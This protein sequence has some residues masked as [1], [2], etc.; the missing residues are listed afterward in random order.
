VSFERLFC[1]RPWTVEHNLNHS[2]GHLAGPGAGQ[3]Q[4]LHLE[5][6]ELPSP[7]SAVASLHV[8]REPACLVAGCGRDV[9]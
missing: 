1:R 2:A 6:R 7:A 3:V 8:Q 5:V 4:K 9:G